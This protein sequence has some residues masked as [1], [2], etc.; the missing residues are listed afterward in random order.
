MSASNVET[1]IE[2]KVSSLDWPRVCVNRCGK[3]VRGRQLRLT[4]KDVTTPKLPLPAPR[5]AQNSSG[6]SVA[7]VAS[8]RPSGMT[9]CVAWG[10]IL[11][12]HACTLSAVCCGPPAELKGGCGRFRARRPIAA[13]AD[14]TCMRVTWSAASP[15]CRDSNLQTSTRPTP[16]AS[17]CV[18]SERPR[19]QMRHL[20]D[21]P[22]MVRTE[23][24]PGGSVAT[25][26][27]KGLLHPVRGHGG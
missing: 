4:V 8:S 12:K 13:H 7:L 3:G 1:T 19:R 24:N 10:A 20:G 16:I 22:Q 21:R 18:R 23:P 2:A 11:S 6:D 14:R 17:A 9:T 27:K 26:L 15:C 25:L 5:S